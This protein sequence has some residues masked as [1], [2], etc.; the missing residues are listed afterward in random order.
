VLR[1]D[2]YLD[3]PPVVLLAGDTPINDLCTGWRWLVATQFFSSSEIRELES[4]PVEVGR[5][6][7]VRYFQLAVEDV[8]W[9]HRTTRGA[10]NKLGLGLQLAALPWLGFVPADVR[11]APPSAVARVA[12]QL[13][14]EAGALAHYGR[15]GGRSLPGHGRAGPEP[16][17]GTVGVLGNGIGRAVDRL[18]PR[19]ISQASH[20][21]QLIVRAG[22]LR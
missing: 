15:P 7:L 11:A 10:P 17:A 8:S 14:V 21:H 20:P 6:E 18:A 16:Q 4:W 2:R 22:G 3:T 12:T 19:R 13:G 9:V 5:D 1:I